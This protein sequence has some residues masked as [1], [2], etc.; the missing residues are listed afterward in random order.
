MI[1][2]RFELASLSRQF[3]AL[4]VLKQPLN[5]FAPKQR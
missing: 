2:W 1:A 5:S 3:C 4:T